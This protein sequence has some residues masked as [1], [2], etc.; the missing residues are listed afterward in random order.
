MPNR[1]TKI[2]MEK[3]LGKLLHRRK[4]QHEKK[5]R[6]SCGK[7]DIDGEAWLSDNPHKL[8]ISEEEQ[9]DRMMIIQDL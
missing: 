3:K 2:K 5:L 9:E 8:E 6:R 7:M 4:E 1:V